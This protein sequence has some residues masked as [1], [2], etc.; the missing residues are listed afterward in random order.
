VT[1]Q[2]LPPR[3]SS[4]RQF[5]TLLLLAL[6]IQA[7]IIFGRAQTGEK[8]QLL[9]AVVAVLIAA[10]LG[11]RPATL[12]AYDRL[13][14]PTPRTRLLCFLSI[15]LLSA[16]YLYATAKLQNR[17]LSPILHD[18]HVYWIQS[19]TL[20]SGKLWLPKHDMAEFF[21]SFHLITDR[22]YAS[23]YGPGA[24]IFFAP[25]ALLGLPIWLTP[26]LLSALAVGLIYLLM[27][28]LFDGAAGWLGALLLL[29]LGIFRRTSTMAM[30]QA[31]E[32][33]LILLAMLALVQWR[34]DRRLRWI[35]GMGVCL[36]WGA[37]TRP[38]D[39]LCVA[40]P[41]ALG[42]I[43]DLF[44][45]AGR[46]SDT[47]L[48]HAGSCGT[49]FPRN[50]GN[51]LKPIA[52]GLAAVTPFLAL[53]FLY[54]KG[55]TG[56]FTQMPWIHYARLYDPYDTMGRARSDFTSTTPQKQALIEEFTRPAYEQKHGTPRLHRLIDLTTR[57]LTGP[58]LRE[59]NDRQRIYGT[60]PSPLLIALLP[61]GLLALGDRKRWVLWSALPL[62]LLIYSQYTFFLPHY[63]VAIAPAVI[64]SLLAAIPALQSTWPR[65]RWIAPTA[66]CLIATLCLTA[67]P[68]LNP[69]R[70]D[71]WFDAPLLRDVDAKLA[72][73]PHT[74][75]VVLFKFDPE[76]MIHEEPVYN[77][78]SAN[79]DDAPVIRAHDL[80]DE[81]NRKIFTYYAARQ[82]TRAFYRYDE[83]TGKLTH[84]GQARDLAK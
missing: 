2:P 36:G 1:T 34:R 51:L 47:P 67:L 62:F 37:I 76:R 77:L 56:R 32:L 31:P 12:A 29:S 18:E 24:A 54:N 14:Q 53:Q 64:M 70:K 22:V 66:A 16:V 30:S 26:L 13:R 10:F 27:T 49:G 73:L 69:S 82:P 7:W 50:A 71:Q 8:R 63:A 74:P 46:A 78:Q 84:L 65:A 81:A 5:I 20:A 35:A 48:S 45:R 40:L 15:T 11:T 33:V 68:E 58:E 75:A 3:T 80:G 52:L 72:G 23:K 41:L 42:V 9:A 38:V 55:V 60:L 59:Q 25:A 4:I 28:D 61:V 83:A 43:L 21:D 57:T 79:P 44:H 6:G 19:K 17:D 39:A